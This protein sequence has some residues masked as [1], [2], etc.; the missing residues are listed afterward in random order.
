VVELDPKV[1]DFYD[2]TTEFTVTE[3]DRKKARDALA[4]LE[5][6]EREALKVTDN[7]YHFTF[8][9]LGGLVMPVILKLDFTDGTS[10]TI[11][12]PAEVW[13]KNSRQVTW[14]YVTPRT[15]K[16]A[17]VDPSWETAD[18]DIANNAFPRAITPL[19]FKPAADDPENNRMKDMGLQVSPDG[20]ATKPAAK[21]D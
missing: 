17:M 7:F 18:A 20:L 16:S 13:R 5:P 21:K 15:L 6:E 10:E 11:R 12:I 4:K 1:R 14:Q 8:S 2:T 3:A 19:T 9:N